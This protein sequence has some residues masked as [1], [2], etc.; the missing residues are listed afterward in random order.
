MRFEVLTQVNMKFDEILFIVP[1]DAHHYKIVE[2]L[3]HLKL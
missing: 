1:T 2:M 3:K